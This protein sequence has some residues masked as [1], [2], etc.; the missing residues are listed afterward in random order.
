MQHHLLAPTW[1]ALPGFFDFN[2]L[3]DE[4][5]Q[6]FNDGAVIVEVGCYLGR[7]ACYLAEQIKQSGKHITLICVDVWTPYFL[8]GKSMECIYENFLAA[9]RIGGLS[10]I[11]L[12]IRGSSCKIAPL[13][14]NNLDAV[15]IDADHSY[16]SVKEDIA[17]W[18]GKVR[19]GGVLAGHDYVDPVWDEVT[20]AVHD[21][22]GHVRAQ[23]RCWVHDIPA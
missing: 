23:G 20:R 6:R 15:F 9:V 18:I 16:A 14:R 21:T 11:I 17:A 8:Q 4:W 22:L 3:Y 2:D 13:L 10:D 19:P 7:S 5:V 1:T 12:P